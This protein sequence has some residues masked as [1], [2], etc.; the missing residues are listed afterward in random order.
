M[1]LIPFIFAIVFIPAPAL[2]AASVGTNPPSLPLTAE[3]INALPA[4][5]QAV[6]HRYLAKSR[7]LRVTDQA[8]LADEL[9]ATGLQEAIVP[10]EARGG[11][12]MPANESPAWYAGREAR[13]QA[14]NVI[15]FQTPA[16]GWTKNFNPTDHPRARGEAVSQD[17]PQFRPAEGKGPL[18]ASRWAY[19]GTFDN[20]ATITEL[21]FLAR[22]I[23]AA[24]EG[25]GAAWRRAFDRG[26][27]YIFSAQDPHG[28]WPQTWPLDGG[29]H[30]AVTFNDGAMANILTLLFDVA[31]GEK[32]FAFVSAA[33]RDRAAASARLG[34]ECVL[35]CQIAV[36]GRRTG[37]C[38][39]HDVLTLAPTSARN[40]EMPAVSG[41]ES[42]GLVTLLMSLP[43]PS[44]EV[45]AAVHDAV[46]WF[47]AVKLRDVEWRPAPDGS[48]RTLLATPGA[49]AL[50]ARYYD[51]RTD[52]PLFGDRDKSI[53]DDVNDISRE[54]RNGYAWFG[55]GP[56]K[57]L[58][59]YPAWAKLHPRPVR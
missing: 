29:Y 10:P 8:L 1:R 37:W 55:N 45:V 25:T 16:G 13:R 15:S 57:V 51:I 33:R 20:D 43:A 23:A 36:A 49:A 19:V 5:E 54:R 18:V 38:Q 52:R 21:R 31:R 58:E 44:G 11:R 22:I 42:A 6:W 12:I 56:A 14:D 53:H 3:R 41:G 9:K 32:A 35:R 27:D 4:A 40:Y 30:D 17:A 59:R 7:A 47:E 26:L 34:L 2:P 50:W 39:Q 46:A 48:G 24:D 28:G